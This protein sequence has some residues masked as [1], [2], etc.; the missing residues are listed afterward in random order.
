MAATRGGAPVL[1]RHTT[2]GQYNSI[3]RAKRF[4]TEEPQRIGEADP[5]PRHMKKRNVQNVPGQSRLKAFFAN[6]TEASEKAVK[7][8]VKRG[9]MSWP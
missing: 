4:G 8:I 3:S 7:Y 1:A 9:G 6:T 2:V 5:G